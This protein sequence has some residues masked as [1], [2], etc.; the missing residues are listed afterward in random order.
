MLMYFK[1]VNRPFIASQIQYRFI[2][3]YTHLY[4]RVTFCKN[5]S[6]AVTHKNTIMI[7]GHLNDVLRLCDWLHTLIQSDNIEFDQCSP[8]KTIWWRNVSKRH[9][10]WTMYTHQMPRQTIPRYQPYYSVN[11]WKLNKKRMKS[12]KILYNF[13]SVHF[14]F[15]CYSIHYLPCMVGSLDS[16]IK[17]CQFNWRCKKT[18]TP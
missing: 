3:Q 14:V 6:K 17:S 18:C 16:N 5:A 8:T 9:E 2:C 10:M 4:H 12:T 13:F 15:H 7:L 1:Y 11:W